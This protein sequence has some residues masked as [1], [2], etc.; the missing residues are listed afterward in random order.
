MW[1][2]GRQRQE[3]TTELGF[4]PA[5]EMVLLLTYQQSHAKQFTVKTTTTR[6]HALLQVFRAADALWNASH[7]FFAQWNLSPSQFNVLNLLQSHPQGVSQIEL[8]RQLIMHRSNATGLVD[9]LERRGMVKRRSLAGDRRA[10]RVVL[11]PAGNKLLREILPRYLRD[12]DRVWGK[13]PVR[14]VAGLLEDLKQIAENA[15]TLAAEL[16]QGPPC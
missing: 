13:L 8:S 14:R 12:A 5:T 10:Y 11:T 3:K 6:Y 4:S 2:N 15:E 9:R 1:K 7:A 16:K